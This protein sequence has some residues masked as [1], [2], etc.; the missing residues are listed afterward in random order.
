M[1]A[2]DGGQKLI[3]SHAAGFRRKRYNGWRRI[4]FT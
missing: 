3:D 1:E 4:A 2:G